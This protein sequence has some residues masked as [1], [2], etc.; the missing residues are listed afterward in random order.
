LVKKS[1]TSISFILLFS[2]RVTGIDKILSLELKSI[3]VIELR[4]SL[5]TLM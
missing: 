4:S 3:L 5:E 2:Y 1:A